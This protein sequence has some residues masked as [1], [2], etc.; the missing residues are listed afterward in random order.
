MAMKVKDISMVST[1]YVNRASAAAADYN[2]GVQASSGQAAA[3]IAA[4][5]LWVQAVTAPSASARMSAGLQKSG[6]AGWK[7]GVAKKGQQNYPNGIRAGA[8][9]Y[10]TNVQPY[11]QVLA[12]YSFQQAKG[13]RGSA[14]NAARSTEVQVLL[15]TARL[16][17]AGG[18]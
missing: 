14:Q 16:Q 10:T 2:A 12:G 8:N 4:I 3:A 11:L 1:K 9:K 13:L 18:G 7:D 5:P 6:D 15:H 17:R